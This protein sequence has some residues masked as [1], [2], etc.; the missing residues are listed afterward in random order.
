AQ[1][2]LKCEP[3][4]V[5]AQLD[6][7]IQVAY[8]PPSAVGADRLANAV[9]AKTRYGLP[10]IVV[11]FGTATTL[12]AIS[13]ESIYVGGAILPGVELMLESLAGRTARLPRVALG[14]TTRPIGRTTPESLRSGV[15]FGSAGAIEHLITLFKQELGSDAH[16]VATGGL[17]ERVAPLCPQ[18]Q[19]VDPL[20]TLEGLR[21]IYER[22][23]SIGSV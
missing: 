16:V 21:T 19:T 13:R 14:D 1:R 2:W 22:N 9:G 8:E 6:L 7:G 12:D 17:A 4:L 18:I 23:C 20:L 11:D 10:A 5:S 3:L 15:L